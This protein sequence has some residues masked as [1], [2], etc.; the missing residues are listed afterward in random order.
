MSEEWSSEMM[1]LKIQELSAQVDQQAREIEAL[2]T[3]LR[4]L[5]WDVRDINIGNNNE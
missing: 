3:E 1:E 4:E 5:Q 2:C